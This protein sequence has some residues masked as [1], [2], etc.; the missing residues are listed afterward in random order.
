MVI[1]LNQQFLLLQE[2]L[3]E[4]D[5]HDRLLVAFVFRE[6]VVYKLVELIDQVPFFLVADVAFD[7]PDYFVAK[8]LCMS[9]EHS[10][11]FFT[12]G[13]CLLRARRPASGRPNV[14]K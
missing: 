7:P 12:E 9:L 5:H 8:V 6:I 1:F 13:G 4:G 11:D 10:L 14:E 3:E 2:I